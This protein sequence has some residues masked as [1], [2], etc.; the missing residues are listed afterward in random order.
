MEIELK[1]LVD[2]ADADRLL[3]CAGCAATTSRKKHLEN[4]YFDTPDGQLQAA[5]IGCGCGAMASAGCRR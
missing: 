3:R 1:L 5:R 4:I 2:P